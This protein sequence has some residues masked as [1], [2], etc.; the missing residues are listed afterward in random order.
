ME[1]W[2]AGSN[3]R[4]RP[5]SPRA[6]AFWKLRT[7]KATLNVQPIPKTIDN[8]RVYDET[9]VDPNDEEV[10]YDE[11]TDEFASYFNKL[12]LRFSSQHQIDLMGEQYNSVNSSPQLYQTHIRGLALKKIIP[13]RISRDFT[14]LIVINEDRKTPNGL[15]LS[16]LPF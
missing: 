13:Q 10:A 12:L 14:D 3:P 16:H 2:K 5:P 11:A 9:A 7:K 4:K 15:I 6:S 8:Q 1:Q